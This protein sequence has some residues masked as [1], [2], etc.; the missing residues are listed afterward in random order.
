ML[1]ERQGVFRA[2]MLFKETV[3]S[4]GWLLPSLCIFSVVVG[5]FREKGNFGSLEGPGTV[6]CI[7]SARA[8]TNVREVRYPDHKI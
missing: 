6:P 7:L 8:K 3:N 5:T 4:N 1:Q 2:L